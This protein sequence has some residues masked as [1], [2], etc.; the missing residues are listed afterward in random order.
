MKNCIKIYKMWKMTC[1]LHI[2][3]ESIQEMKNNVFNKWFECVERIFYLEI[4]GFG[5]LDG[6][7][8]EFGPKKSQKY[9]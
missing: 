6:L 8:Y 9:P 4:M 2:N 1:P 7:H 5:F 3:I